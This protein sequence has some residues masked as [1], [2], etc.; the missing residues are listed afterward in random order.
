MNQQ[1]KGTTMTEK[2]EELAGR[3]ARAFK[4]PAESFAYR[5]K[6][7]GDCLIWT[8]SVTEE[9]YGRISVAGRL[10]PVHRWAWEQANG[11][12]PDGMMV[13][14]RDHCNPSCVEV[15]H[16][17]LATRSQNMQNR[18]GANIS[19]KSTG[20]RNVYREGSRFV[21]KVKQTRFGSYPTLE[22]ASEAAGRVRAELF[23]EFAG[24]SR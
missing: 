22:Q 21:V 3:P 24:G 14:H 10:V 8:G 4:T 7:V 2:Y 20:V 6:R 13:D 16:L 9:G 5:A 17:R 1:Q 18:A 15:E 19:N 23:G 11:P 12:I